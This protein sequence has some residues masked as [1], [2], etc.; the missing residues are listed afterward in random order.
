MKVLTFHFRS[1]LSFD[2]VM[3]KAEA[4]ETQYMNVPGLKQIVY[5][6]DER[7]NMYG[8]ILFFDDEEN[9]NNFSLSNLS[10][11]LKEVYNSAESPEVRIFDVIKQLSPSD[12]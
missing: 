4:R 3:E 6:K 9:L 10:R 1:S 5:M 8:S 2:E 7:T 11:T 12:V